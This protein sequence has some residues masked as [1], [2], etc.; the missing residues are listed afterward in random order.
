MVILFYVQLIVI[1]EVL[2]TLKGATRH[3]AVEGEPRLN[4]TADIY[5]DLE[6]IGCEY[7]DF[8]GYVS[9]CRRCQSLIIDAPF[10]ARIPESRLETSMVSGNGV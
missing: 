6:C 2:E 4:R 10:L 7:N 1:R 9:P 5:Y 8:L 3:A